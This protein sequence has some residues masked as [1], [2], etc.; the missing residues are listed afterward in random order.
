MIYVASPY[1][2]SLPELVEQRVRQVT[3]FV[4]EMIAQGFVAFSPI[5]YC[6]PIAKRLAFGTSAGD[7]MFFNM[8]MLRRAEAVYFL[9]LPGWEQSCGMAIERNVCKMLNM[10]TAD[11]DADFRLIEPR[12]PGLVEQF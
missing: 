9:R 1:S 6:H 11:Y 12:I 4:E 3:T 8:D 7:W 2:S 5:M 10:A